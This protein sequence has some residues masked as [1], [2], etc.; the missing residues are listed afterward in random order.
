MGA[1]FNA[2]MELQMSP[3][4]IVYDRPSSHAGSAIRENLSSAL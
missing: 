1:L 4:R 3:E 2:P